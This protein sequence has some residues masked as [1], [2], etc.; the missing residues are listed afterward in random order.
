MWNA[1]AVPLQI[2]R[3]QVHRLQRLPVVAFGR[4]QGANHRPQH[5]R[6]D[7]RFGELSRAV[8]RMSHAVLSAG[9]QNAHKYQ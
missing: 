9:S 5:R 8:P 7:L 1:R 6:R 4:E 2:G 3:G